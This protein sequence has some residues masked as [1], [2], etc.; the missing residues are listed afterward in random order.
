MSSRLQIPSISHIDMMLGIVMIEDLSLDSSRR[1][2]DTVW[3]TITDSSH[4][5]SI[6]WTHSRTSCVSNAS[7]HII[8]IDIDIELICHQDVLPLRELVRVV[9]KLF[10]DSD[11]LF[12]NHNINQ[13][14]IG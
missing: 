1:E 9:V 14:D 12:S 2:S 3:R 10:L 8:N 11:M 13:S 7:I 5:S 4:S 6:I